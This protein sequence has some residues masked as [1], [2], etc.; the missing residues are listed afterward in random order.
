[1]HDH[2]F[3]EALLI[4]TSQKSM[5]AT[6]IVAAVFFMEL[7]DTTII[8]TSLPQIATSF[9]VPTITIKARITSY[10]IALAVFTPISGWIPHD[11]SII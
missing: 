9:G 1:V 8:N 4:E 7:L 3:L 2:L 11:S 10:L 5:S 6:W